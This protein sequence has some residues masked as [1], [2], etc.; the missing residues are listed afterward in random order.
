VRRRASVTL[1]GSGNGTVNFDVHSANHMWK[2]TDVYCSTDQAQTTTPYP[3]VTPYL[4]G[5]AQAGLAEGQSWVGNQEL[6]RGE[7]EVTAGDDLTIA[8]A[9]GVAGSVATVRIEGHR[10][11]WT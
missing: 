6:F 9:G 8:F 4:G 7:I 3:V 1:D 2:I 10:Y 5:I 11:L